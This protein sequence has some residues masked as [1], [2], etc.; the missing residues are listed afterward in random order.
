MFQTRTNASM[1]FLGYDR[2]KTATS[3]PPASCFSLSRKPLPGHDA[4][5]HLVKHAGVTE[6]L[7]DRGLR[8]HRSASPP[9]G[10]LTGVASLSY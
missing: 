3:P 1:A 9:G 6:K 5:S 7:T 4:R 10:S 8:F 2:K